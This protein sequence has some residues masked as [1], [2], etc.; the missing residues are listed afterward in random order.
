[1]LSLGIILLYLYLYLYISNHG[2]N[3][4]PLKAPDDVIKYDHLMTSSND[5]NKSNSLKPNSI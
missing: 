2:E 5:L 1:M 3:I 4:F